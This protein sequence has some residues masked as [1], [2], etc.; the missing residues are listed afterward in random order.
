MIFDVRRATGFP[1]LLEGR[2]LDILDALE[3]EGRFLEL[4]HFEKAL[5]QTDEIKEL[6]VEVT[7]LEEI[8][9]FI[10]SLNHNGPITIDFR[11]HL[12]VLEDNGD[13]AQ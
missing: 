10:N 4:E 7:K 2:D 5:R 11:R 8:L 6:K 9:V 13:V 3:Y 1:L 12:I